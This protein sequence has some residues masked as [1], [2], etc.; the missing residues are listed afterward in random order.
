MSNQLVE[1]AQSGCLPPR[2]WTS[3][4][5]NNSHGLWN[6]RHCGG[7]VSRASA[8]DL[9]GSAFPCKAR[10]ARASSRPSLWLK[11]PQCLARRINTWMGFVRDSST[12]GCFSHVSGYSSKEGC[13]ASPVTG[14]LQTL[15]PTQNLIWE[16]PGQH[17]G[18]GN[19]SFISRDVW[20]FE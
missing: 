9:L 18:L 13:L 2:A 6:F 17:L 19:C 14:A 12:P 5:S 16:A 10:N 8:A 11:L 1:V 3:L 7:T 20:W 4:D 15:S